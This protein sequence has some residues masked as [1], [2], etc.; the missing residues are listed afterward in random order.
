[1]INYQLPMLGNMNVMDNFSPVWSFFI[2]SEV[3]FTFF[4]AKSFS[5]LKLFS[6]HTFFID[7]RGMGGHPQSSESRYGNSEHVL[8]EGWRGWI[9][10]IK[11]CYWGWAWA[12]VSNSLCT[13]F[14]ISNEHLGRGTGLI[15]VFHYVILYYEL[16]ST[17]TRSDNWG[18]WSANR[19]YFIYVLLSA[20]IH[21]IAAT[22][23][24]NWR[25]SSWLLYDFVSMQVLWVLHSTW[26]SGI[27]IILLVR[28]WTFTG[29]WL[30]GC[31]GTC[32]FRWLASVS[33][34]RADH[35]LNFL[36]I[37]LWTTAL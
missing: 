23:S 30:I 22:F 17:T 28:L 31:S 15:D 12:N 2:G 25:S 18:C 13:L 3:D 29:Q 32:T 19:F 4:Q 21:F 14:F 33:S 20:P 5:N 36:F 27:G 7:F 11:I 1:M 35:G 37:A 6:L 24:H 16:F 10:M 8:M 34:G 9:G 26:T